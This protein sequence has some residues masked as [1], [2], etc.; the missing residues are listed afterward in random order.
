MSPVGDWTD[1]FGQTGYRV[2]GRIGRG[3][4]GEVFDVEHELLGRRFAAKVLH[5]E[6]AGE[7]SFA[8]RMRV[9]AQS[10]AR[11]RHPN[12]VE[13]TDFCVTSDGRPCLIMER[14]R[15]RTLGRELAERGRLPV[16]ECMTAVDE[17]LS[18]LAAAHRFGVVHRDLKPENLFLHEPQSGAR[19]LKVLDF[20]LARVL[21]QAS[22]LAPLPAA[23]PTAT[24]RLVGT[25]RYLS[26]EALTGKPV[27]ARADLYSLGLILYILLTGHGPFDHL[28]LAETLSHQPDPPSRFRD[29]PAVRELDKVVLRALKKQPDERFQS[30]EEMSSALA[31]VARAIQGQASQSGDAP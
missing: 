19:R 18:A 13:V 20:G 17:V 15:G 23:I 28:T 12:I 29:E 27:D 11:L 21:P 1:L 3:A 30:A 5:R 31:S 25:P 24:G 4:M 6:L 14:L 22:P 7:A 9:E 26:P 10:M 2:I 16:A 8:E